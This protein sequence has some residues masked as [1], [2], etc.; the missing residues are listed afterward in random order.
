ME[1]TDHTFCNRLLKINYSAYSLN[2]V[3]KFLLLVL[4]LLTNQAPKRMAH[5]L[6]VLLADG[7]LGN[8]L[9]VTLQC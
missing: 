1:E 3:I 4:L 8:T 2:N 6:S 7:S 5:Y 9:H